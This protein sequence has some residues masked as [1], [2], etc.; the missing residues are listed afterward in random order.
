MGQ[1]L[2]LI[3]TSINAPIT[4][5]FETGYRVGLTVLSSLQQSLMNA[6]LQGTLLHAELDNIIRGTGPP[7]PLLTGLPP[8]CVL[9]TA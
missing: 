7:S 8:C 4:E 2:P 6:S 9:E 5:D 3:C 1:R